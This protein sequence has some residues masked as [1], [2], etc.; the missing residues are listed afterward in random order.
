MPI[1]LNTGARNAILDSGL[2][3]LFNGAFLDIYSG[4]QPLTPDLAP[5]GVLLSSITLPADIFAA[6]AAGAI[7]K[8]GVWTDIVDATGT[9]GYFRFRLVADAGGI[10]DTSAR[11]D[12]KVGAGTTLNGAITN[13]VTTLTVISTAAFPASGEVNINGERITYTGKTLTTFTGCVRGANATVAAAQV[14]GADV[15][16]QGADMGLDNLALQT[17]GTLTV[18]TFSFVMPPA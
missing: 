11:I 6:A 8:S 17:G 10:N 16:E 13:A 2:N 5:T 3:A 7:A 15:I 1:R 18:N 14:S 4:A 12:G 9:P